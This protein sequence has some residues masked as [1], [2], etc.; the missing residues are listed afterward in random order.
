MTDPS[1][2]MPACVLP[3]SPTREPRLDGRPIFDTKFLHVPQSCEC[4]ELSWVAPSGSAC[5][6]EAA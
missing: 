5:A 2:N 4:A 1:S 3:A 6:L